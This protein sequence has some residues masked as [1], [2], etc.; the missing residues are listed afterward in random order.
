MAERPGELNKEIEIINEKEDDGAVIITPE[1]TSLTDRP[2]EIGSDVVVKNDVAASDD[3]DQ[4]RENIEETRAEMSETIDAIQ[5]RLSFSNISEQVKTEVSDYV[6]ET[7]QTTKDAVLKTVIE[8]GEFIMRY[9]DKRINE[10]ADTQVV[11]TAKRN[12]LALGLIGLGL[13]MLFLGSNNKKKRSK[14]RYDESYEDSGRDYRRDFSS[15]N[16]QSTLETAQN[17][18]SDAA[19]AVGES[20]SSAAGTVSDTVGSA[21]G[22]VSNKVSNA[23]GAISETASDVADKAYKQVGNLGAKAQDFAESTQDNFEYYMEENPLA[24]GAV[25]L[26][27]GAAVGMA[28]PSTRIENRYMGEA[29][30]NLLQKAEETARDA[31]GKVQKVAGEVTETVKEEAKNQGLT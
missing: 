14:F 6:G 27:L 23:A 16:Q 19:S 11:K 20:V 31:V 17:K 30:N 28:F 21:A 26:A 10:I 7:F 9:A 3:P 12:P 4:I 15:K 29:R 2:A 22:A 24:V 5:E 25:A 13:G 1:K 8:K 18:L